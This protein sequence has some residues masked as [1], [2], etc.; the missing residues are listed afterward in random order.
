ML[1]IERFVGG[2]LA[3]GARICATV[4]HVTSK[5]Y[6]PQVEWW[7]SV[8]TE[9]HV[10]RRRSSTCEAAHADREGDRRPAA[11]TSRTVP[12]S[13]ERDN[14]APAGGLAWTM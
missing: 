13:Y 1:A 5:N 14:V 4:S 3:Q 12:P 10:S 2:L 11:G 9:M 8:A 6:K 7:F